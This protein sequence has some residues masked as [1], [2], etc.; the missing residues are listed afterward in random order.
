MSV[1]YNVESINKTGIPIDFRINENALDQIL[2]KQSDFQVGIKRFKIPASE[3]DVFRI[4]PDR[5]LI[6]AKWISQCQNKGDD[7][8]ENVSK[9]LA[10]DLFTPEAITTDEYDPQENSMYM[11]IYSQEHFAEVLSRTFLKALW[12]YDTSTSLPITPFTQN[13]NTLPPDDHQ[14]IRGRNTIV[15][16]TGLQEIAF[17]V[18]PGGQGQTSW[19]YILMAWTLVMPITYVMK[20]TAT[21]PITYRDLE[22]TLGQP[23]KTVGFDFVLR[24]LTLESVYDPFI[25]DLVFTLS[26]TAITDY[27]A[28]RQP[29][30]DNLDLIKTV[31]GLGE[32]EIPLTINLAEGRRV[33]EFST[34]FPYGI[35]VG[36]FGTNM[37]MSKD[38]FIANHQP[39]FSVPNSVDLNTIVG[40]FG[41]WS[42]Y[43]IAVRY[44]L[45]GAST[46]AT[47]KAD[48]RLNVYTTNSQ[49]YVDDITTATDTGGQRFKGT[50]RASVFNIPPPL[51]KFDNLTQRMTIEYLP[52]NIE[53][54]LS[55][56]A[57]DS[58]LNLLGF[59][60]RKFPKS[61]NTDF[62]T[63]SQI[64]QSKALYNGGILKLSPL[65]SSHTYGVIVLVEPEL[66]V[67]KR[68]WLAGISITSNNMS[69]DGEYEG[70]GREIRKVI[71]DFQIDPSTNFRDYLIYQP[72]GDSVRYYDMN[73]SQDLR[74]ISITV[75]YKDLNGNNNQLKIGA[76]YIGSVKL[77][78]RSR[79][80]NGA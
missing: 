80:S 20:G 24:T 55:I 36:T 68:N 43:Y 64:P 11:T 46:L 45:N 15:G 33:S 27:D 77:H 67:F 6:G 70:N 8:T 42:R 13:R 63:S 66:S 22:T 41:E 76:G 16:S 4:Y 12:E 30:A 39:Y 65:T 34:I 79:T 9:Y 17:P 40:S 21:T 62:I 53:N 2:D 50:S 37:N 57:N 18:G 25:S 3:V 38:N 1:Y 29:T 28:T 73:S 47:I 49:A 35:K 5:Y 23:R 58:L 69:V 71:S 56:Y 44:N 26:I 52:A 74:N 32:Y 75:F 48:C 51:F 54:G 7:T 10:L 72:A 60:S 19:L 59:E 61:L 31:I 14:Q 78:F